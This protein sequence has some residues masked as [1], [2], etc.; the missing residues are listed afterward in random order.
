[1]PESTGISAAPA[2]AP[3]TATRWG[4]AISVLAAVATAGVVGLWFVIGAR[5]PEPSRVPAQPESNISQ[6]PPPIAPTAS[7]TGKAGD[8][9]SEAPSVKSI[10]EPTSKAPVLDQPP[11]QTASKPVAADL[12]APSRSPVQATR[13][14][15]VDP[16]FAGESDEP[17]GP[18]TAMPP[19]APGTITRSGR[20][21][22]PP[23]A[24]GPGIQFAPEGGLPLPADPSLRSH[25]SDLLKDVPGQARQGPVISIQ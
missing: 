24:R 16:D 14:R 20:A 25:G 5:S 15:T 13:A 3:R 9:P 7:K 1:M 8:A 2:S 18:V 19:G 6:A 23:G 21:T 17:L 11:T 10:A 22:V 4:V 12:P